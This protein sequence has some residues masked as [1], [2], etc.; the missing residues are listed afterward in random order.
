MR[1]FSLLKMLTYGLECFSQLFRLSFWRHPFTAEHPLVSK[2]Y[3]F[4]QIWWRN[5]LIYICD[6]L[7][8]RND[9][10]R[11]CCLEQ[12]GLVWT[13]SLFFCAHWMI[14][15][16]DSG[17]GDTTKSPSFHWGDPEHIGHGT[18]HTA[19]LCLIQLTVGFRPPAS[20]RA[21]KWPAEEK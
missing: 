5:K 1:I 21:I 20:P 19:D 3:T 10:Y 14:L 7:R 4:L 18:E 8:V 2:C 12:S 9:E 11:L 16:W 13:N 6:S 17:S 15:L